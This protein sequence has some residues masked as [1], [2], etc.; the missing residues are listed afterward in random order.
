[1][2]KN[3]SLGLATQ[4]HW[5]QLLVRQLM[6]FVSSTSGEA[7]TLAAALERPVKAKVRRCAC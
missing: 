6:P 1:M 5:H 3:F 7:Y 4:S 2:L